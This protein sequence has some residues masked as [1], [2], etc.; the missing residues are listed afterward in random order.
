MTMTIQIPIPDKINKKYT[1]KQLEQMINQFI[2]MQ[3]SLIANEEAEAQK[4]LDNFMLLKGI[5][6]DKVF[7]S[8]YDLYTQPKF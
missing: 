7:V 1:D 6:S 5:M 2:E 3:F 8:E 4:P